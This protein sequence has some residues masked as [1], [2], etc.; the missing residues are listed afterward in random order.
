[1]T[2]RRG[3]FLFAE[4]TGGKVDKRSLLA[5]EK[6]RDLAGELGVYVDAVVAGGIVEST[7]KELITYGA[8]KV[9]VAREARFSAYDT[10][11][12]LSLLTAIIKER[13][14]EVVVFADSFASRDLGPRLAQRFGTSF[15]AA[16]TALGV[17]ERERKVIQTRKVFD[18][19]V[20][21]RI[22]TTVDAPQIFS[23]RVDE[24]AEPYEADFP[25]GEVVE[26]S[27][28]ADA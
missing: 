26:W 16:C 28:A 23:V 1:M 10:D 3:I 25:R 19:K 5:L 9:I 8:K 11:A 18:G 22:I 6:A 20:T 2:E 17:D 12:L 21:T 13:N 24:S 15:V 14:P 27:G 7:A 4:T